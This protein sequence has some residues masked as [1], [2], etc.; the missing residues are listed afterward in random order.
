[1][2]FYGVALLLGYAL[3]AGWGVGRLLARARWVSHHPRHAL[4]VWHASAVAC[5]GALTGV[6]LLLAHDV[7]EHALLWLLHADKGELHLAYAGGRDIDGLWNSAALL[8]II[9]T[10]STLAVVSSKAITDE[11]RRRQFRALPETSERLGSDSHADVGVAVVD[12]AV[13]AAHC[14]PG[15]NGRGLI[16]LT[17]ATLAHLTRPEVGAVLEHERAHLHLHHHRMILIADSVATVLAWTGAL[18]SYPAQV[19]RLVELEADD[20]AVRRFGPATVASALLAMCSPLPTTARDAQGL[21]F[22]GSAVAV[23]I[24]RLIESDDGA[25]RLR[26]TSRVLLTWCVIA[27]LLLPPATVLWPAAFLVGSAH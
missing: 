15:R 18:R 16:V 12:H 1:M 17:S 22:S 8:P 3:A 4:L 6:S 5:L 10:T 13:P 14:L 9:V 26:R 2:S 19:R 23:R 21:S 27:A 25:H 20:V 24:R 7:L 11:R